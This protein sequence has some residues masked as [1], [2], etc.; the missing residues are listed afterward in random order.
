MTSSEDVIRRAQEGD[1][2][3]LNALLEEGAPMVRRLLDRWVGQGLGRF[4]SV[5][6]LE[7]EVLLRGVQGLGRFGANASVEEFRALLVTHTRWAVAN[8]SRRHQGSAGESQASDG[9]TPDDPRSMG[10]VT[11]ADEASWLESRLDRLPEGQAEVVRMRARGQTFAQIGKA[12]GVGED[13]A[14][15]RFLAASRKIR[16]HQ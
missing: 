2:E 5:S 15:K 12:I 7:Q 8:A 10:S 11:R 16:E 4:V 1:Q 3:A 14:R 13:A 6:D 9:P